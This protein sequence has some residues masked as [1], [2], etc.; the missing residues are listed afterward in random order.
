MGVPTSEDGYIPAMPRRED[1]EVHK[2]TCGG[3]GKKNSI[4]LYLLLMLYDDI[5]SGNRIWKFVIGHDNT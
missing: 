4:P 2:R 5:P 3:V 1:Y